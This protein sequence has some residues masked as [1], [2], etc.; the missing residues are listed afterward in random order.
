[1]RIL[2][3]VGGAAMAHQAAAIFGESGSGETHF[4]RSLARIVRAPLG[5]VPFH[6]NT[7]SAS[8]VGSLEIDGNPDEMCAIRTATDALAHKIITVRHSLSLDLASYLFTNNPDLD[9]IR[10]IFTQIPDGLSTAR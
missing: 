10:E 4:V 7:D 2:S 3:L 8:I 6:A 1:M 9:S 5:V